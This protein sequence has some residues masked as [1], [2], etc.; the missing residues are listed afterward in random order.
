MILGEKKAV[1]KVLDDQK[2]KKERDSGKSCTA[3][4]S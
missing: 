2:R 4:T 3:G 1:G